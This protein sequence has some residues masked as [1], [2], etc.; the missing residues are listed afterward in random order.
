MYPGNPTLPASR[1]IATKNIR[2]ATSPPTKKHQIYYTSASQRIQ[3]LNAIR[4]G[5]EKRNRY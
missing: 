2:K 1:Q 5:D 4:S 3:Q